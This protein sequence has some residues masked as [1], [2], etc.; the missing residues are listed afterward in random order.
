VRNGSQGRKGKTGQ[1]IPGTVTLSRLVDVRGRKL[2]PT[3]GTLGPRQW[4]IDIV[5]GGKRTQF[6][7]VVLT[8]QLS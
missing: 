8:R 2:K 3:N 4:T 7:Q 1:V 6:A 5:R